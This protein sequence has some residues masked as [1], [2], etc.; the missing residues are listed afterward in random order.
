[1]KYQNAACLT[2]FTA[3]S[4]PATEMA[5]IQK[6]AWLTDLSVGLKETYDDNVFAS[7][8]DPK[9]LPAG[10]TV[11]AGSVAALEDQSSWVTT[12]SPKVGVNFAP[13]I[14]DEEVLPILSLIYAPDFVIYHDQHSESY[15]A[16]RFI[17][18]VKL[19]D[20]AFKF[21]L[22]NTFTYVDG[23]Q[24]G[25]DYPGAL[26]N[27]Y[28]NSSVRD[29]RE[30]IQDCASL[31]FEYDWHDYFIRPV[32][33]LTYYDMMTAL[34]NVTGYQNYV[35]RYDVNGGLD[36]GYQLRPDLAV[37]LGY[38]MGYQYQ[39]LLP[40]LPYDASSDYNRV[41]VGIEGKPWRWL[42]VKIQAG[43]DFRNYLGNN[44]DSIVP[45]NDPHPVKYYGEALIMATL[46]S[47]DTVTFK[48]KQWQWVSSIG[49][50]PY[51]D[52]SFDLNYHR[53]LT[54][55]LGF[56]LGGKAMSSD[57]TVGN[58]AACHRNDL[59][60]CVSIGLGYAVNPHV[61]VNVAYTLELGRNGVDGLA[62][63]QTREYERNLVTLGMLVKF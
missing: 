32:A 59:D 26:F 23:S 10:Y 50:V 28:M 54:E 19:K 42:D 18:A 38:R 12:V 52:S 43:P 25:P 57:Y 37:T 17:T 22:N 11:P 36:L 4:V 39:E 16:H 6:P 21:A 56:D 45:V 35:D 31:S 7:G 47:K 41:L 48:Y 46:T 13:L 61:N 29:R 33:S 63:E 60:Y 2:L 24:F 51:Y 1:M 8:V 55:K 9:Y 58:L 62:N 20:G 14:N 5:S 34:L 15:D 40:F 49:K 3:L 30:Q 27:A 44:A 53:K